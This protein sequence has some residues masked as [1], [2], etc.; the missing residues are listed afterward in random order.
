MQAPHST[1]VQVA[2]EDAAHHA[3]EAP[4]H[5]PTLISFLERSFGHNPFVKFLAAWEDVFFAFVAAALISVVVIVGL[6]TPKLVPTGLQNAIEA[7]FD[8]LHQFFAGILG[9]AGERYAPFSVT[10]FLYILGM[11][12]LGLVPFMKSATSVPTTTAALAICVFLYVQTVGLRRLGLLGY[13]DHMAGSPRNIFQILLAPLMF[14]LHIVGE[15]AKPFSLAARLFGNISGEDILMAVF[16]GLGAVV[17]SATHVPIPFHFPFFFLAVLFST[18][19]ALVFSLLSTVYI[20]LMLP[21][22]EGHT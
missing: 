17:F 21:H 2:V 9:P 8:G 4:S 19:Q 14:C 6:R 5:L 12:L 1:D 13:L 7:V 3:G 18:L 22:A 15:I 20:V 16:V 11:N 10:L